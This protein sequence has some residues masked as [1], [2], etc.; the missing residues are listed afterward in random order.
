MKTLVSA[1]KRLAKYPLK[2]AIDFYKSKIGNE[3]IWHRKLA[4]MNYFRN[5]NLGNMTAIFQRGTGVSLC[6]NEMT[7]TMFDV[8]DGYFEFR[9]YAIFYS[10]LNALDE[11]YVI[12]VYD[13]SWDSYKSR[14]IESFDGVE[15]F[16]DFKDA[17]RILKKI[18]SNEK[19]S[20][21]VDFK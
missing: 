13:L 19:R 15:F 14:K 21:W 16:E 4:D 11:Y 5:N 18:I 8:E 6:R 12:C 2:E 17:K 9:H 7:N 20:G 3:S 1:V 10:Q